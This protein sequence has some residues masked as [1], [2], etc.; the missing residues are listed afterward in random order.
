MQHGREPKD[1]ARA[2]GQVALPRQYLPLNPRDACS[3]E[4]PTDQCHALGRTRPLPFREPV[5]N[6]DAASLSGALVLEWRNGVQ[7]DPVSG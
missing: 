1:L 7:L 4:F 2:E 3:V 5:L 6:A